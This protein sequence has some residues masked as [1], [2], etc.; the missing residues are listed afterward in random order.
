MVGLRGFG[1]SSTIGD[2]QWVRGADRSLEQFF[3]VGELGPQS[4]TASDLKQAYIK[5]SNMIVQKISSLT[6]DAK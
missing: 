6:H 1:A 4:A 2:W 3:Q 5:P